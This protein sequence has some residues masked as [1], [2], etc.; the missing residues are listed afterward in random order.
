MAAEGARL[1]AAVSWLGFQADVEEADTTVELVGDGMALAGPE[2][3]PDR[4]DG[5]RVMGPGDAELAD[6]DVVGKSCH[7]AGMG[8]A[9]HHGFGIARE[10][11]RDKDRD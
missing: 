10:I 8:P 11:A 1:T 6:G 9:C 5:S 7:P 4:I 3:R 2:S